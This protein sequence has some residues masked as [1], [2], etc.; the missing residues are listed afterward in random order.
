MKNIVM[1]LSVAMLALGG[2]GC[3]SSRVLKT[4]VQ[5]GDKNVTLVQTMDTYS[6]IVWPIKIRHQFWKCSEAPGQISCDKACSADGVDLTCPDT[7]VSGSADSS[8]NAVR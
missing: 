7:Y 5:A 1:A 6:F 8:G 2:S 3:L 4:V